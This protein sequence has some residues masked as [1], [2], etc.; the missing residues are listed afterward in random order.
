M[1]LADNQNQGIIPVPPKLGNGEDPDHNLY[2]GAAYG[3]K[4]FFLRSAEW[5]LLACYQKPK[6]GVL[7]RCVFQ[8]RTQNVHLVADAYEG[9]Q[10]KQ[11]IVD[12]LSAAAGANPEKIAVSIGLQTMVLNGGGDA[13][14]VAYVGHDGLMDFQ[15]ATYPEGKNQ[16]HRDAIILS[17][18]SKSYFDAALR[19]SGAYPLL[20]TN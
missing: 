1:A 20:W 13:N 7:E 8:H 5:R 6:V 10:I 12:F 16:T 4:T 19:A 15:L 2:W 17:C 14:L 11:A 3:V 9:S 18:A